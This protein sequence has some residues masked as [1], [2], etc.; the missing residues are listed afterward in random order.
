VL[1]NSALRGAVSA[2]TG[3]DRTGS[4]VV[5]TSGALAGDVVTNVPGPVISTV[6]QLDE[7]NPCSNELIV[8][9]AS[10][11]VTAASI[12]ESGVI[13]TDGVVTLT[14]RMGEWHGPDVHTR[15]SASA[16]SSP[17]CRTG[18]AGADR[19]APAAW[20][21]AFLPLTLLACD[22]SPPG[23]GRIRR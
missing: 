12:V 22:S 15:R 11:V 4:I 7:T 2:V 17:R 23:A 10:I 16:S 14:G 13:S 19:R 6:V 9:D 18:P 5:A 8:L 21:G 3:L 20:D 1:S